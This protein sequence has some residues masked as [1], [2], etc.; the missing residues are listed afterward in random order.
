M[1]EIVMEEIGKAVEILY[2]L[3]IHLSNH[4]VGIHDHPNDEGVAGVRLAIRQA[5]DALHFDNWILA[6]QKIDK[7]KENCRP[8]F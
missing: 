8:P 6:A 7:S 3:D 2:N 5:F 1:K 4:F